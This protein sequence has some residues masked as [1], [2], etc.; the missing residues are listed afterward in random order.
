MS[1]KAVLSETINSDLDSLKQW[2]E[3]NKLSL[4][5][6]K[7]QAVVTGF[8]ARGHLLKFC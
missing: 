6:I 7:T 3:G 2:L 4:K 1:S 5:V 8:R